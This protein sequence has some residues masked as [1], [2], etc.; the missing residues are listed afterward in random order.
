M[1]NGESAVK[2]HVHTEMKDRWEELERVDLVHRY[3]KEVIPG[4]DVLT[5]HFLLF[6]K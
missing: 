1:R 3:H 5:G 6:Q 4:G 2:M